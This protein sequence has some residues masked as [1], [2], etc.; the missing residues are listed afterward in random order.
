MLLKNILKISDHK[1]RQTEIK[2][3]A[4]TF[5]ITNDFPKTI[6]YKSGDI[7]IGKIG[8]E[9]IYSLMLPPL[10]KSDIE[11]AG[12]VKKMV[13][14]TISTSNMQN[15]SIMFDTVKGIAANLVKNNVSPISYLIA[16]DITKYGPFSIIMDNRE[17]IEEIVVNSPKSNLYVYHSKYGY[18][19]TNLKFCEDGAFRFMINRLISET[20]KEL[21]ENSPIIDA[22]MKDG[23]R[24]HAQTKPYSVEG[25]IASIRLKPKRSISIKKLIESANISVDELAYIWMALDSSLNIV[26]AGAPAAGKTTLLKV[27]C[28]FIPRFERVIIVEEDI[29][30]LSGFGEFYNVVRLKGSSFKNHTSLEKQVLNSLHLRPDRLVVGELRGKEAREIMFGANIGIPFIT[31]M[32]SNSADEAITRLKTKPMSVEDSLISMVDLVIFL[33]KEHNIRKIKSITEYR[34]GKDADTADPIKEYETHEIFQKSKQIPEELQRSKVIERFAALEFITKKKAV[35]E[36]SRRTKYL[37][38]ILKI[39]EIEEDEYIDRY[40]DLK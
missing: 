21:N 40:G 39:S 38:K 26:L 31:T 7:V 37:S 33:K 35:I 36:M 5:T 9:Y 34:W 4:L 28:S 14:E 15:S 20:E 24:I 6:E 27:I 29:S 11:E 18:C 3:S 12:L 19:K 1:I 8:R 25:G 23:S 32:H 2:R 10:T 17:G 13:V 16:H 30:E 22:H